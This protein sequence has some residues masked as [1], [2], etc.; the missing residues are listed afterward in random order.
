MFAV[1]E[2]GNGPDAII[3][4]HAEE[5][6]AEFVC[7]EMNLVASDFPD[8]ADYRVA[9]MTADE[10]AQYNASMVAAS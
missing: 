8:P 4:V 6:E 5:H 2:C 1:F 10:F 7:N 3:S 9:E